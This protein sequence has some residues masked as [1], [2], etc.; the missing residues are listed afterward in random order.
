MPARVASALMECCF[1]FKPS[2]V[3]S[4]LGR[5][6]NSAVCVPL[7]LEQSGFTGPLQASDSDEFSVA[8][9]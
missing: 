6:R 5:H 8:E 2:T 4:P 3:T 1:T 9:F 7:E